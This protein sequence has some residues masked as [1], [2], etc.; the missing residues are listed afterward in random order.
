MVVGGSQADG[1]PGRLAEGLAAATGTRGVGVVDR[2]A[3]SLQAVLVLQGRAPRSA[4][5]SPGLQRP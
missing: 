4:S 3:S 1:W 5:R 2:E